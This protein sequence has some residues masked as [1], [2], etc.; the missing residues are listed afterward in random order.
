[1]RWLAGVLFSL[2]SLAS[3]IGPAAADDDGAAAVRSV[4]AGQMQAF[5]ADDG[6]AAYGYAAPG[7][8]RI[9]PNA[10]VFMS[11][12]KSGYQPVYRPKSV[13][14]GPT[15][16]LGTG[17]RQEVYLVGPDGKA[18]T[19]EYLLERQT[20]GSLKISGVRIVEST[21]GEA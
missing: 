4:I 18:Y 5:Q 11:M 12:V 8:Q 3:T 14:Y 16:A 21:G 2:F 9:F 13:V 19:A 20:D 15:E 7:I 6:A 17:Y 1:M 10:D